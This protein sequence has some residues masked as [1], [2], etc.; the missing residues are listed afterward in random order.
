MPLLR[1]VL[2]DLDGTLID[3]NDAHAR[4][5]VEVLAEL[6]HQVEYERVRPLIG[7]GSDQLLPELIGVSA[8]SAAGRAIVER[9]SAAFMKR[10]LPELAPFPAAARLA[11]RMATQGLRLVVATSANEQEMQALVRIAGIAPWLY[12]STS[13]SEAE[14]SKP[15]PD[16]VEVAL[17]KARCRPSEAIMLGDTPYDVAAAQAA[18]VPAIALR[19]GGWTDRAL[20]GAQAIYDDPRELL[21]RYDSSPLGAVAASGGPRVKDPPEP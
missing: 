19:C 16:I 10:A 12:G 2:L 5:W 21:Q 17:R 7:K 6:G 1:A 14:D 11:E 13:A 9:R 20:R 4:V 18:G 15:H 8:D 3:S